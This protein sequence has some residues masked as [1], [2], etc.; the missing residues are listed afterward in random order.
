[1]GQCRGDVERAG[2]LSTLSADAIPGGYTGVALP[3]EP[4]D[5]LAVCLIR[6]HQ[7]MGVG[8]VLECEDFGRVSLIGAAC[9][10]IDDLLERDPGKRISW[11]TE[12][13]GAGE[14]DLRPGAE[15][16]QKCELV[17]WNQS[18]VH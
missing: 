11:R 17:I 1:M 18:S 12:C 2:P 14:E 10:A 3:S 15:L 8:N 6:L 13:E 5:N 7:S 9:R 4:N 16:R